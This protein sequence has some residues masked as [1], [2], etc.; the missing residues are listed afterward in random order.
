RTG[1]ADSARAVLARAR[2][3][4]VTQDL[5]L[6]LDYDEAVL[7]LQLGEP[8]AAR[9]AL[10]QLLSARPWLR[11]YLARDPLLRGMVSPPSAG[12]S[13]APTHPGS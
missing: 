11:P 2:A 9:A 6:S 12:N 4:A 10:G 8:G 13:D 3:A 7:R 1:D 5:R